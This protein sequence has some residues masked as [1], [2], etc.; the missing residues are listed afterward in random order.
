[1]KKIIGIGNALTDILLQ[2]D[3]NSVLEQLNLPKASM[4][5]VDEAKQTE[6]SVTLKEKQ[7]TMVTGGSTAN[8]MNGI[9]RL[10]GLA[11]YIGKVGRDEVGD[12][13]A[14][15]L[16]N[17]GV[18]PHLLPSETPSG[19]CL[20]LISPDGERTMATYLGA[21]ATLESQEIDKTVFA[22]YDIFHIEGYLVQNHDLIYSV[23]RQAK[24]AGLT[25]SIDLASY[26]V[27]EANYEFLQ[28]L[29]ER[30]VDIV[31][32]NEEEARAFSRADNALDAL[33]HIARLTE[34]AVVKIGKD[35][36]YIKSEG[37][38]YEVGGVAACCIDTTGAGDL[39]AAG[40]LYGFANDYQLDVCGRIGS[41]VAANVVEVVGA[42]MESERWTKILNEI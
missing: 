2:I 1:M 6:I 35:G 34:I 9:A 18:E 19:R 22:D 40:F 41:L 25:V 37:K 4:Q 30:Y 32:A 28:D 10:G 8:T 7:R 31:F 39:Y 42:K 36:S 11:G 15:D 14:C 24:E 33:E 38:T 29:V 13:Y 5:L 20:V 16:K 17:N 21:A 26:N 27:V 23:A 3:D 12:F